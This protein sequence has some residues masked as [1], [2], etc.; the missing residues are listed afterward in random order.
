MKIMRTALFCSVLLTLASCNQATKDGT[1]YE[2]TKMDR[3]TCA[4]QIGETEKLE[5]SLPESSMMLMDISVSMKGYLGSGDSRFKGVIASYLN[6]SKN[7]PTISLFGN[8][9]ESL[10]SKDDFIS[11]LNN[12]SSIS[13]S[14]ES[15][16]K[17]M[18]K[19]MVNHCDE[20]DLCFLLTDGILSGSNKQISESFQRKFN[21]ENRE[22][23]SSEIKN[24]FKGND[25]ISALIVKYNANFNGTYSCYNN[26]SRSISNRDRPYYIVALGKWA[27]IKYLEEELM[28]SKSK[29]LDKPYDNYALF[30]DENTYKKLKFSYNSGIKGIDKEGYMIIKSDVRQGG[31]VIL[32]TDVTLLPSYMR[33]PI[34][35]NNHLELS[36]MKKGESGK[37]ISKDKYSVTLDSKICKVSIPAYILTGR[38]LNISLRY[39]IP[40]WINEYTD[41]NDLNITSDLHKMTQTFNLK[42][43]AEGLAALQNNENVIN[44]T[45]KFK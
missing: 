4:T 14:H 2:Q 3:D 17:G 38:E 19:S 20:N 27:F 28:N 42:Y 1:E 37:P 23:L 32:S 41:E 30:G 39:D 7:E 16:L 31:D 33:T 40:S 9:E 5:I 43:F 35:W 10:I 8:T 13:W 34:Y 24:I 36:I 22:W 6:V 12:K 44:Q 15:D 11:K 26:D 21:I 25:S 18:L 29:V 45:I